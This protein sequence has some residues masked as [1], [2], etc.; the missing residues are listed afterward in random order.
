MSHGDHDIHRA[1][2]KRIRSRS[3]KAGNI[4]AILM[5]LC[6]PKIRVGTFDKDSITLKKS[7]KVIISCGSGT[8]R[9]G[10]IVSQYKQLYRD[11]KKG[12]RI[13]LDDGNMECRVVDVSGKD[14]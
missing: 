10:L 1:V 7:A 13:L 14:I 5:D 8:G 3:K 11:V 2:F 6:G 12:E 9:E 4:V